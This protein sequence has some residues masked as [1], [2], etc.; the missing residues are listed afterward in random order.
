MP[1]Y[2]NRDYILDKC[3]PSKVTRSF[4]FSLLFNIKREKYIN[5][6]NSYKNKKIE[7]STIND[8]AYEIEVNGSFAHQLSEYF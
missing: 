6:C 8:K 5:L 4:I 7:L 2:E 1:V 3:H